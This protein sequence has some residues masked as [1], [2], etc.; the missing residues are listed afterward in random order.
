MIFFSSSKVQP[1]PQRGSLSTAVSTVR[2]L[3]LCRCQLESQ[4][5]LRR[6]RE[7]MKAAEKAR[8]NLVTE[9]V[10]WQ[11]LHVDEMVGHFA[12]LGEEHS[13]AISSKGPYR[14]DF[15]GVAVALAMIACKHS[16]LLVYTHLVHHGG[17]HPRIKSYECFILSYPSTE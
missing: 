6:A 10:W 3:Y 1:Q 8:S 4:N 12:S 7:E 13:T 17:L 9:V 14:G 11:G 16:Q 15:K 5:Q 2:S